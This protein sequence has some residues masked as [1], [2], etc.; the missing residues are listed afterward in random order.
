MKKRLIAF[1]A[2]AILA[3]PAIGS[4]MPP[5]PGPYVSGFLGVS[6][7]IDMDVTSTQFAPVRTFNDRVEFDSSINFGG[8]GGFD[9][10]FFRLEG[11]LSYRNGEMSSIT[12]KVSQIRFANVNGRVEASAVMFN[13][14]F[15]LHNPSYITPYIGGGIGFA[16]LHLS[17]TFGTDTTTGIRTRLYA[18]DDDSVVA[19]QVGAGLE[20]ALTEMSSLDIG[21]RYFGTAKARFNRNTFTETELRL[22]SHNASVGLRVKF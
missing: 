15:D 2:L 20:I 4:A 13:A 11:E 5:R 21:Y 12:E 1:L 7:P 6:L 16:S 14:F 22:E 8:T 17:E 10:G 9:F 18:S 19:Y 3:V